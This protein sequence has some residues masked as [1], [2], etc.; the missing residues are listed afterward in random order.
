MRSS[1]RPLANHRR[2]A[3][4]FAAC[5]L[6]ALLAACHH[7]PPPPSN[8][9]PE[10]AIATNLRLT[11]SGDF[12][13]LMKNRLPPADYA[14]W[15]QEWDAQHAHPQPVPVAQ[16]QQFAQIMQMLTAPGAEDK[17]AKR[18]QAELAGAGG[19]DKGL[20]P[21]VASV[22]AATGKDMIDGS[23]QL[24]TEQRR[25][26]LQVLGA[27]NTWAAG[28]DF[29]DREK[30][31]KAI[32]LVCATARQLH[33][34]TLQQWQAL[35][36]AST[37]RDYGIVWN[38]IEGLLD[39]YGLDLASS[40]DE[41]KPAIVSIVSDEAVVQLNLNVDG[42]AMTGQWAMRRVGG[43]WYDAAVLDAW[44]QAHPV[45]PAGAGSTQPAAAT[46]AT[47]AGSATAAAPAGAATSA[48]ASAFLPQI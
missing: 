33:V 20:P 4:P 44:R 8:I 17:L 14:Q 34:Q 46:S 2:A 24:G 16:Q 45:A 48:P 31:A 26:A 28:V 9:T 5:A 30:L 27:V 43:H 25:L 47:P 40:L 18:L 36:Y 11:A 37:M 29:A 38:G 1:H 13:G 10:K 6:A 23:P 42:Q 35:D 22:L 12:D 7:A 32:D 41:G 19:A 15:R 3:A 39:I 21:V